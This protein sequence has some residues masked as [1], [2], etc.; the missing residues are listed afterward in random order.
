[1]LTEEECEYIRNNPVIPF[2]AETT[3]YPI[4]FFDSRTKEWEGIAIDLI[5]EIEQLSGLEFKRINDENTYWPELLRMLEDGK[6]SMIT[7]LMKI[8]EREGMYYGRT[9][10]FCRIILR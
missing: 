8:D 5:R 4:S 9:M 7:E 3:N 1:M 2:A 6:V 10:L